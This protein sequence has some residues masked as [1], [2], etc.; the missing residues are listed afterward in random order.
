MHTQLPISQ[1][2]FRNGLAP[3]LGSGVIWHLTGNKT[4]TKPMMTQFIHEYTHHWALILIIPWLIYGAFPMKYIQDQTLILKKNA[5]QLL[6]S[7]APG[8]CG[9]NL[10]TLRLRQNGRHFPDD[11]FKYIFLNENVWFSL[12]ISL[13]FVHKV[14]IKKIPALVQTMAWRRPGDKP[15]SEPMMVWLP[16]HI[17]VTRPQWVKW[18]IL[19]LMSGMGVLSIH[20]EIALSHTNLLIWCHQTTSHCL[21]QGWH[22]S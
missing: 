7:L 4:L 1:H 15:L 22:R 10:N 9:C 11:I 17:C 14:P 21:N 13:K 20:L 8:E 5:S 6:N 18:A 19:K 2:W 16:T 12:K 3:S